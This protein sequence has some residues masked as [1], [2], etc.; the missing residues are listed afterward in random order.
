MQNSLC[1]RSTLPTKEPAAKKNGKVRG[2]QFF[3]QKWDFFGGQ[4]LPDF[5]SYNIPKW[6]NIWPQNIPNYHKM[7]QMTTEIYQMT[8]KFTKK[9]PKYL[10]KYTKWP[11]KYY[12]WASIICNGIFHWEALKILPNLVC[13]YIIWQPCMATLKR[14]QR[15][16][17][18]WNSD[19]KQT[20]LSPETV[21]KEWRSLV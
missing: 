7:Y 3:V 5:S 10:T 16:F 20:K 15:A 11:L 9:T 4:W 14:W 17:E 19:R 12:K 6:E 21:L 2:G 8:T 13:K 18:R 1:E